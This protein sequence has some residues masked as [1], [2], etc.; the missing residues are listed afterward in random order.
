M[1]RLI[2]Y[3]LSPFKSSTRRWLT[4]ALLL[5]TMIPLLALTFTNRYSIQHQLTKQSGEI[6]SMA[7]QQAA[8][9]VSD[10]A[11]LVRSLV[12]MIC[13]DST[14]QTISDYSTLQTNE[15]E[16]EWMLDASNNQIVY[17]GYLLG[18]VSRITLYKD[19][20]GKP[21]EDSALFARMNEMQREQYRAW[22]IDDSQP[23][24]FITLPES[25][26]GRASQYIYLITKIPSTQRLGVSF[27]LMQANI[28]SSVFQKILYDTPASA[29][30]ALY[31]LNSSG[32]VFAHS[33]STHADDSVFVTIRQNLQNQKSSEIDRFTSIKLDGRHYLA[34]IADISNTGW[35]VAMLVPYEDM[36]GITQ[37]AN[38]YLL[39]TIAALLLLII[40]LTGLITRRF[41]QPILAL[42]RGVNAISDGDYSVTIPRC[43][44]NDFNQVIDSFN[45][46][47]TRTKE[48]MANQY[49][50]GQ[51]LKNA[52]LQMLQE[53]I[54]PHFLYNTLDLLHWQARKAG[55]EDIVD[56]V[57]SLSQFYKRSLGHGMETVSLEHELQH[58]EAYVH[59]Q[60]IRFLNRIRLIIDV[61]EDVR[62]CSIVKIALQPL[63]ENAIQ[64][65]IREKD[66]ES[67]TILITARAHENDVILSIADDGVGMD[68]QTLSGILE[69]NHSGHGV[70][71]VNER[72]ILH[73]GQG[74]K[75]QFESCPG[76][77][78]V[79]TTRIPYVPMDSTS[80]R[81]KQ[82]PLHSQTI[83]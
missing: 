26:Y 12:N 8:S 23:H 47:T 63:V 73:Y 44:N 64:H 33:G 56:V 6:Y 81:A 83:N 10:K 71:N 2:R 70:S 25:Q 11:S 76:G 14:V 5:L 41:T 79:V 50:M 36:T 52:E 16:G 40:P 68:E 21:F 19:G 37:R 55:A 31:L 53:Q 69:R 45:L 34:G 30:T 29:N 9:F 75:L 60:N 18:A 42:Q 72:L 67:G 80:I 48:M 51:A 65:G 1:K 15:Y 62:T 77:G 59:I 74:A 38:H 49:E 24:L 20:V 46:M 78:T 3:F 27:G 57:H 35:Q 22:L 17:K 54:N 43:S 4:V 82:S 39:L 58:I 28:S 13:G 61:P 66:D 7:L 32:Q